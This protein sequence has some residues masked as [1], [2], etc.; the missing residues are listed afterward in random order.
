[1][2]GFIHSANTFTDTKWKNWWRVLGM[3]CLPFRD[4]DFDGGGVNK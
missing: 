4:L 2:E 3:Q 1:M